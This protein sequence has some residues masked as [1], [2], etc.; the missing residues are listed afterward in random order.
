MSVRTVTNGLAALET[1]RGYVLLEAN[2]TGS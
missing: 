2:P 1:S